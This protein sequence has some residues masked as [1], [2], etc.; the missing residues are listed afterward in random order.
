MIEARIVDEVDE[1]LCVVGVRHRQPDYSPYVR[2]R[3]DFRLRISRFVVDASTALD[4]GVWCD[5]IEG[6]AVVV[7]RLGELNKA[8]D[9]RWRLGGQ[10]SHVEP[11]DVSD[12]DRGARRR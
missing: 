7:T 11:S 8:H 5:A 2:P 9:C 6:Q 12:C 3:A 4:D 1:E 10:Q